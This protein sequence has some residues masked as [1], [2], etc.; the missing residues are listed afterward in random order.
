[1]RIYDTQSFTN[2]W[3]TKLRESATQIY[4][5]SS[6]M[7]HSK[8]V[9]QTVNNGR[10]NF[11]IFKL[12]HSWERERKKTAHFQRNK[13]TKWDTKQKMCT[14]IGMFGRNDRIR[15]MWTSHKRMEKI[16]THRGA[17]REMHKLITFA[18]MAAMPYFVFYRTF[19]SSIS[20]FSRNTEF[21][22][23]NALRS[24]DMAPALCCERRRVNSLEYKNFE[25][26]IYAFA[27]FCI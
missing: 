7:C 13:L 1:M 2:I 11:P 17:H 4:F 22:F 20:I 23:T 19:H 15:D 14:C 6:G 8:K 26:K 10:R 12:I 24:T 25:I 3:W 9:Y 18:T 16:I 21:F 5:E 27:A